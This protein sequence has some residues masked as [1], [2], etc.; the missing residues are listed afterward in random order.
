MRK[1]PVLLILIVCMAVICGCTIPSSSPAQPAAPASQPVVQSAAPVSNGIILKISII[2]N[3]FD[4]PTPKP[5]TVGT[6][7]VWTNDDPVSH[8]VVH[9][10]EL[11]NDRELFRSEPLSPGQTFSYTFTQPGR[12]KYSDPQYAGGRTALII[13]E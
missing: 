5:I 7:V 13:V 3:A 8:R 6:T 4:P 9:L 1:I 12:Y 11:P 2:H 10:P